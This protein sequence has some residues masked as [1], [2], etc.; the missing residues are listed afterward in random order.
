VNPGPVLR[1]L[2]SC[3]YVVFAIRRIQLELFITKK[4]WRIY[5]ESVAI[6]CVRSESARISIRKRVVWT[7][8]VAVWVVDVFV[9]AAATIDLEKYVRMSDDR[10]AVGYGCRG[11]H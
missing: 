2:N 10:C 4:Y 5:S 11:R 3:I 6:L 8:L 1:F 7:G 9:V